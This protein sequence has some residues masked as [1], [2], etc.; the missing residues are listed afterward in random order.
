VLEVVELLYA[1][2]EYDPSDRIEIAKNRKNNRYQAK[3][4]S[5]EDGI[6]WE[7]HIYCGHNPWLEARLVSNLRA[8]VDGTGFV[9][10]ERP[11]PVI[12][13]LAGS[14]RKGPEE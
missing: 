14:L 13:K 2:A 6:P 11:R 9:W 8:S 1:N 7:G 4:G 10:D 5:L 12:S 3:F